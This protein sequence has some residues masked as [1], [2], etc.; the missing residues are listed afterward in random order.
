MLSA[1]HI[2]AITALA[3]DV[4]PSLSVRV[5]VMF[6]RAYDLYKSSVELSPKYVW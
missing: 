1:A 5:G 4:S 3:A 6:H 2:C